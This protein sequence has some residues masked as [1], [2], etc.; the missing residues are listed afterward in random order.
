MTAR[1][2][3]DAL[4]IASEE[5]RQILPDSEGVFEAIGRIGYEFEH[6]IADLLDNSVDAGAQT[7]LIRFNHDGRAVQSV[8]VIDDG[9]G[10][11]SDQLDV[12]MS[13]GARAGKDDA[14][15][16]KYGMGLKSASFSQCDVL[17]VLSV[18]DGQT[19]GRRWIAEKAKAGWLCEVL[20]IDAAA[21]YLHANADRIDATHN[22][23][24]VEWNRLDAM[25]HS[26]QRP[27]QMID[28]RF[29][30]LSNHLG[31]V[32]HRFLEEGTLRIRMDAVDLTSGVRGYA[33]D[34]EPLNPFPAV[35]GV[36]GYPRTFSFALPGGPRLSFRG[37]IWRRDAGEAGFKLGGGR[38]AKRQGIYVYRNDRII[39]AGGWN[40]LRNEAEVHTSLARVEFD[41]PPALDA[42]FKPTVQKSAVSMP[43]VLLKA[44]QGARSGSKSFVDY[45]VDAEQAYRDQKPE[46]LVRHGLVPVE[47]MRRDLARRFQ[48]ILGDVDDDEDEVRF[49]WEPLPDDRLVSINA[50][51]NT[52]ILNISYREQV[53]QFTRASSGDAPLVKTLLMLLFKDDLGR[54]N[55]MASFEAKLAV[56]NQLLVEAVRAQG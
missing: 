13:F 20:R 26:M 15:L 4:D 53:L 39:Q 35:T 17:T 38:L 31:L 34:V 16:G 24:L 12:A 56:I 25:S 6:A 19:G 43:Q 1:T 32:F 37:H 36:A 14:S 21:A 46:K 29:Q 5:T 51:T 44:L 55:R 2:A 8:A 11:T 45:L 49:R 3:S 41:L 9:R 28:T 54:R 27:D 48:R 47:G 30:Q 52:I 50:A 10:M 33:Q 7:V 22:G 40:G 18:A 23:T 42:T